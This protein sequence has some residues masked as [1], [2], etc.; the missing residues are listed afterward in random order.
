MSCGVGQSCGS[1]PML[2]WLWWRPA[3]AAPIHPLV[4]EP[5]YDA[6]AALKRKKNNKVTKDRFTGEKHT[7][8]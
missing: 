6:G 7:V 5:P 2:L 8:F 1:A 3:A 4:W